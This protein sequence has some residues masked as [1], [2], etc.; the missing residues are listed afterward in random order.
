MTFPES[1]IMHIAEA[2]DFRPIIS[3]IRN[4]KNRNRWFYERVFR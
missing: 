3:G 2:P 1:D 4:N